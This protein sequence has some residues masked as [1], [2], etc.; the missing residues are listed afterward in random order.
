MGRLFDGP[1]PVLLIIVL[2]LGVVAALV[3]LA[4]VVGSRPSQDAAYLN[5]LRDGQLTVESQTAYLQGVGHRSQATVFGVLGL[6]VLGIVFGP[7]AIV[8]AGRA[9]ALG[10]TATAGKVLG[11]IGVGFGV[12]WVLGFGMGM[13]GRFANY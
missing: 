2:T 5:R 11:W 3:T 4:V 8:Q 10:V 6:F 13:A 1:G 7:L 12:L 9:E